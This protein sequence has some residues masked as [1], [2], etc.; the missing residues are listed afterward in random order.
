MMWSKAYS[1]GVLHIWLVFGPPVIL[2]GSINYLGKILK[3]NVFYSLCVT[4]QN[5][6]FLDVIK[7]RCYIM[8]NESF[9]PF[10]NI[11]SCNFLLDEFGILCFILKSDHSAFSL[12]WLRFPLTCFWK[13][14]VKK[15]RFSYQSNVPNICF[16]IILQ[17]FRLYLKITWML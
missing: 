8:W 5:I 16:Q 10:S 7:D 4:C 2:T 1:T 11:K 13:T 3:W 9:S 6:P 14:N 17:L 12:K 15:P